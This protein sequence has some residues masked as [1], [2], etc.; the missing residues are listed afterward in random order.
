MLKNTSPGRDLVI[1]ETPAEM[2]A[3]ILEA[4]RRPEEFRETAESG[5]RA[6]LARYSWN[7]LAEQLDAV[8]RSLAAMPIQLGV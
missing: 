5:R 1:T 2:T 6:V 8:W 3:A 4:I 7:R